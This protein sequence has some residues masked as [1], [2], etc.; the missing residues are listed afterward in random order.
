MAD[1]QQATTKLIYSWDEGLTWTDFVFAQ[2]PVEVENII[3]EPSNT[4]QR[5][6]LY[7]QMINKKKK[8][9]KFAVLVNLDFSS[10][11]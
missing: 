7:G 3:I 4:G 11:H 8:G 9:D 6:V 2:S 10:L 1:D 5:F